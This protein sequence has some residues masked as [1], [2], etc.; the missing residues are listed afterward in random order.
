MPIRRQYLPARLLA[1]NGKALVVAELKVVEEDG[2]LL[3]CLN[4]YDY[5]STHIEAF[6]R[7]Y[8]QHGIDPTQPVSLLLI[9]R[10]FSQ[11]LEPIA[12]SN[13]ITSQTTHGTTGLLCNC[14]GPN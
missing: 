5:V 14:G 1:D 12:M 10:S 9:A 2:M 7:M 3:Q 13:T 6:S 8:S 11:S 4:Y